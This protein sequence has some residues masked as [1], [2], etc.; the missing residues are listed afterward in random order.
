[1]PI[2][3]VACPTVREEDGLAMSS[4]NR[5]LSSEDRTIASKVYHTLMNA[6]QLFPHKSVYEIE[7]FVLSEIG[8]EKK[9]RLEYFN[10]VDKK[11]LQKS[12]K[13]DNSNGLIGCVAFWLGNVRLID[14]IEFIK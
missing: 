1:L 8:K 12:N 11:T 9:I 5:H 13:L 7:Q 10:I 6:S 4:R 2:H 3:V 14:N